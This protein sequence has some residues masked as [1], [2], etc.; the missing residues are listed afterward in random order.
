MVIILGAKTE[1]GGVEDAVRRLLQHD[2]GLEVLS[3]NPITA[4]YNKGE[5]E[6][7]MYTGMM[8]EEAVKSNGPSQAFGASARRPVN[9]RRLRVRWESLHHWLQ[10]RIGSSRQ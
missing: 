8:V 5:K 7:P 10:R 1:T 9:L 3:V 2:L 6:R 4:S